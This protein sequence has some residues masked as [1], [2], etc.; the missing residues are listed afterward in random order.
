MQYRRANIA[1][2]TYFFTVNL[3]NR[4]SAL[5]LEQIDLLREAIRK[6]RHSHPFKIIAIVVLPDHLHAIWRLPVGDA[7]F[8]L[9]WA[10]I[11][12]TFSRSIQKTEV[13]IKSRKL[14]RE[15]GI[16][17]RRYW[18]HLIRDDEDLAKHVAYI[19][20]NPVKHGYVT[21]AVDWPYSSIH[22]AIR[23]GDIDEEWGVQQI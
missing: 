22:R 6:I 1:G 12:A 20:F 5:L 15:R 14:K 10:L 9:R 16:W 4:K 23:L 8:P 18:E 2:A 3:A 21:K 13:I 17:Q 19:Y 11:K 7:D